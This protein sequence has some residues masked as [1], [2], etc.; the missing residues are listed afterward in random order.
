M[1][2]GNNVAMSGA[3]RF[4]HR[5]LMARTVVADLL[6]GPRPADPRLAEAYARGARDRC[7]RGA[8][9]LCRVAMGLAVA[10]A[11][12]GMVTG[13]LTHEADQGML[14]TIR[15]TEIGVLGLILRALGGG[16]LS[17]WP[18]ALGLVAV[19][20]IAGG[21]ELLAVY[22]GGARSDAHSR[23]NLLILGAA[24]LVGWNG[25]W[26]LLASAVTIGVYLVGAPLTQAP[27]AG[28]EFL[29]NMGF[30]VASA[31]VAVGI[32]AVRDRGRWAEFSMRQDLARAQEERLEH[33]ERYRSLV[34]TAA[35]PIVV[36]SRDY[37]IQEFNPEAE[38]LH[39]RRRDEVLGASYLDLFVPER[40][41]RSVQAMMEAAFTGGATDPFE[42]ATRSADGT[43]RV[44][45]WRNCCIRDSAGRA[46]ALVG[47]G[48]DI[49]ERKAAERALAESESRYR[50]IVEDQQEL[51]CRCT[52]DG[53][54]TFVND[55]Y[56][57]AFGQRREEVL[58]TPWLPPFAA[59]DLRRAQALFATLG[60]ERRTGDLEIRIA[61]PDGEERWQQWL[62]RAVIDEGRVVEFQSVGRDTTDR[63]RAEDEVRTL[64]AEL[65][66]RVEARTRELQR[67]EERFRSIFEA[68]PIGIAV[69]DADGRFVATNATF[70]RM[71]GYTA[72]ELER[73]TVAGITRREDVDRSMEAF[74]AVR[75]EPGLVRHLEKRYVRRDGHVLWARTAKVGAPDRQGAARDILAMVQDVTAQKREEA[76]R[77]GGQ[78]A[79]GLVA[80]RERI[81]VAL[82][83]IV[84]SVELVDPELRCAVFVAE[85]RAGRVRLRLEAA[86]RLAGEYRDVMDGIDV[87]AA[88][89]AV[90]PGAGPVVVDDVAGEPVWA[91]FRGLARRQ[92]LHGCWSHP[93]VAPGGEL[94]GTVAIHGSYER[95]PSAEEIDLAEGMARVAGV[96]IERK[97]NDDLLQDR[98]AQLAHVGR[99]TLV[100]E[101]AAGLAHELHQP[102]AAVVAYAGACERILGTG[103]GDRQKAFHLLRQIRDV[104]LHGGETIR[105]LRGFLRK[106]ETCREWVDMNDLVRRVARLA[107]SEARRHGFTLRLDLA[108][109]LPPVWA[110]AI[111]IEQVI[112]NLVTNG[113]EAMAG[114]DVDHRELVIQSC[115]DAH[116]I[117]LAVRDW[118]HGVEDEVGDRVFDPFFTTKAEGLGL[119]LSISRSIIEAHDGEMWNRGNPDGGA[120]F[121]FTLP[122]VRADSLQVVP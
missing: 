54:L 30:L 83:A 66:R 69:S 76:L 7:R 97:Q 15:A 89:F 107:E 90:A 118:G 77:V 10:S 48:Q 36:L 95:R 34:E 25:A 87:D 50:A 78:R 62:I 92:R 86:P 4:R 106:G 91:P 121:G 35:S 81:D 3:A 53:V 37:R 40:A 43:R 88:P 114:V 26:S 33:E 59:G 85:R 12:A 111:Q 113:L 32:A 52:P 75:D 28:P 57:R 102:L 24:F 14:L 16:W 72:E 108:T 39:G 21:M 42:A 117:W 5:L 46:T 64:N 103:N 19:V 44:L 71:L 99:L 56:C 1:G 2:H 116:G 80:A 11:V 20:A 41:R 67:S 13:R 96:V 100:G 115:C 74:S 68:A 65:E 84:A 9:A 101:L 22:D 93:I 70:R 73:L 105:R 60:P 27:A 31:V 109:D 45:L 55:A 6:W 120:T 63:K 8:Q 47:V 122:I 18:R 58:G 119:G 104:A 17:R 98:Q 110:D 61:T 112:L 51:I 29:H 38:R 23:L 79:L 49:T 94:L 82:S